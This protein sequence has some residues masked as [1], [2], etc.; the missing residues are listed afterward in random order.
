MLI[1]T[2]ED[3]KFLLQ[4]ICMLYIDFINAFG[5]INHRRLLTIMVDLGYP[6][7]AV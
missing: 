1:G 6:L 3:S 5:F 4:D 2:L 7:D